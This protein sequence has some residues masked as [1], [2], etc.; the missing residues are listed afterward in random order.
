MREKTGIHKMEIYH[1]YVQLESK[2]KPIKIKIRSK[3][4]HIYKPNCNC[5][6]AIN[7]A[8]PVTQE[9]ALN[10]HSKRLNF[11]PYN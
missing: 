8:V 3:K 2:V 4:N 5:G 10:Y 11:I 7:G 6:A 1:S 9:Q